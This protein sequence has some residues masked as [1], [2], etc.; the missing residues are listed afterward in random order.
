M[1]NLNKKIN[2]VRKNIQSINLD[3]KK[4]FY[5]SESIIE[6]N[7]IIETSEKQLG[8]N[9]N[10]TKLDDSDIK[11]TKRSYALDQFIRKRDYI[12]KKLKEKREDRLKYKVT[13]SE[14]DNID[15]FLNQKEDKQF[16]KNWKSLDLWLKKNRILDYIERYLNN[17]IEIKFDSN[18]DKESVDK[19]I[20]L[21][22][23]K[24]TKKSNDYINKVINKLEK[25]I[26]YDKKEGII[27][28]INYFTKK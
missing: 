16:R 22:N 27:K 20:K 10:K 9:V 15:D 4:H 28:K 18:E 23:K 1:F 12:Q 21:L 5:E 17:E 14:I 24:I 8:I 2:Q 11:L 26:Q 19:F 6:N 25:S 7:D 13:Y 3:I